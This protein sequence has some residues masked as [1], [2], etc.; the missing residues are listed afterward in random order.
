MMRSYHSMWVSIILLFG[1]GVMAACQVGK[2][3]MAMLA[4]QQELGLSLSTASWLISAFAVVGALA[5]APVGLFVDRVGAKQ[6]VV[7]SLLLMAA[8]S[9]LGAITAG[10]GSLMASRVLEGLGFLGLIVAAPALIVAVAT[11]QSRGRAMALWATFMPVGMTIAMLAAPLLHWLSWRSFWLLNGAVLLSYA[12]LLLWVLP[13]VKAATVTPRSVL[14]DIAEAITAPGPWLLCGLFAAFSVL[15]FALFGFLPA[16]LTQ[17]LNI[18]SEAASMLSAVAIAT[19]GAGNLVCGQ[20]LA[21]GVQ[22]ARLLLLSFAIM[23]ICAV[24]ALSAL[25]PGPV[26]YVLCIVFSFAGGL[27]PVVIFTGAARFAPRKELLGATLGF[28]MQGNNIGLLLGPVAA[29]AIAGAFGWPAV[30]LLVV[31]T[32]LLAFMLIAAAVKH[33]FD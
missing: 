1:A 12:L 4:V 2:A 19:S 27:V 17:R 31:I 10:A 5:G 29:G 14:K 22:P 30:S 25:L 16:L 23:A 24:G 20:L 11:E 26:M 15:F 33:S 13:A 3:P 28:A 21:R 9:A 7:L 18:S 8:G 6:M 32:A